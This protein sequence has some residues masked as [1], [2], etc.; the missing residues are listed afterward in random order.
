MYDQDSNG[1]EHVY[2]CSWKIDLR[3]CILHVADMYARRRGNWPSLDKPPGQ[4]FVL[5]RLAVNNKRAQEHFCSEFP[6]RPKCGV[7]SRRGCVS[8]CVDHISA[9]LQAAHSSPLRMEITMHFSS[10]AVFALVHGTRFSAHTL[11]HLYTSCSSQCLMRGAELL[12]IIF[13]PGLYR[14]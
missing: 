14:C 5:D 7:F 13:V 1:Y 11:K 12:G 3:V 9:L 10:L 6:D 8:V 2:I 4:L